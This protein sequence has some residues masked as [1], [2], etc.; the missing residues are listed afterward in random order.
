MMLVDLVSDWLDAC[1]D[2][3]LVRMHV[4][5]T[6][7]YAT[8]NNRK[9]YAFFISTKNACWLGDVF[10]SH[11]EIRKTKDYLARLEASDPEFFTKLERFLSE[12]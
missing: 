4:F 2:K 8:S 12:S 11:I 7:S 3:L 1:K 5:S 6:N 9:V 10:D